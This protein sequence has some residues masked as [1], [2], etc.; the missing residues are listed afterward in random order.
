MIFLFLLRPTYSKFLIIPPVKLKIELWAIVCLLLAL[1]KVLF[2]Q[3]QKLLSIKMFDLLRI[4]NFPYR[5]S[6]NFR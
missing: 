2:P 6:L 3:I 4:F 5:K 1:F